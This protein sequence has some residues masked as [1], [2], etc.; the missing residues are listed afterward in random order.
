MT[1]EETENLNRLIINKEIELVIKE[2]ST[3]KTPG[4]DCFT[5]EFHKNSEKKLS[6]LF[7]SNYS[8]DPKGGKDLKHFF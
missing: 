6:H 1:Q 7:S 5:G 2:L 3:N 4:L 8:K